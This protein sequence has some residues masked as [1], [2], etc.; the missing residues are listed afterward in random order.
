M[1]T[2]NPRLSVLNLSWNVLREGAAGAVSRALASGGATCRV[3]ELDLSMNGLGDKVRFSHF[4]LDV[5]Y[6]CVCMGE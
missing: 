6:T 5:T 2:T 3:Q 4:T 1:L